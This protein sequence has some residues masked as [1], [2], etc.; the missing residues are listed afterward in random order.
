[1]QWL[2]KSVWPPGPFFLVNVGHTWV[3]LL[4]VELVSLEFCFYQGELNA[5]LGARSNFFFFF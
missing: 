1:M 4:Y 2:P 5:G 3:I